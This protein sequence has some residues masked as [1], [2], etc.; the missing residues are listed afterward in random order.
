VT[1]AGRLDF[2][3]DLAGSGTA[4]LNFCYF[5]W[6]ASGECNGGA[7]FHGGTPYR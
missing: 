5:Q 7:T 2:Y 6:F 1:D 4:D 3:H